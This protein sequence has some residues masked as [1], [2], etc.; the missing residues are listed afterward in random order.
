MARRFA[1]RHSRRT[2]RAAISFHYDVSNAFYGLWLDAERVYSCAYFETADDS[3]EQAQRN[4]LRNDAATY[5]ASCCR[6]LLLRGK[7]RRGERSRLQRARNALVAARFFAP[8]EPCREAC[9]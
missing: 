8:R 1:H 6:G 7:M 5:I 2:D 4:K 3:L 9:Y